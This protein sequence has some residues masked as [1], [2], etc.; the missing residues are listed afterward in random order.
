VQES[1]K[2]YQLKDNSIG[3]PTTLSRRKC[4]RV[5]LTR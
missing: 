5:Y 1:A 3:N 2:Q 4:D